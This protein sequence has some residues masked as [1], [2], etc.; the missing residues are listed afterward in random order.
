MS[1]EEILHI[2]QTRLTLRSTGGSEYTGGMDGSG[3]LYRDTVCI[4]LCLD[5]EVIS[6]ISI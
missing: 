6:E 5:D 1:E 3:K 2:L 4:Q